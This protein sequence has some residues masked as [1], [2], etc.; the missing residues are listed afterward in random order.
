MSLQAVLRR[1]L[2][3]FSVVCLFHVNP[4]QAALVGLDPGSVAA[5][6]GE[7]LS[8]D[9]VI[10]GL[11]EFA[12]DSLGAFDV[13]VGFDVGALSFTSYSLGSLLGDIGLLEAIDASFGDLGGVINLAEVSLLAAASLDALQSSEFVLATLNFEVIDLAE[14][15]ITELLVQSSPVLADGFGARIDVTGVGRAVVEGRTSIPLPGTLVLFMRLASGLAFCHSQGFTPISIVTSYENQF[16][17]LLMRVL[18]QILFAIVVFTA[19]SHSFSQCA[20]AVPLLC[21]ADGDFD[22]DS[23][24]IAAI[25]AAKGT[26]SSGPGDVRDIDGDGVISVLDAR[27]CV[28]YCDEP[29]CIETNTMTPEEKLRE[30]EDAGLI[31]K[32]DRTEDY[33]QP[34]TNDNGIR[35]DIETYINTNFPV[36][37]QRSAVEQLARTVQGAILV[38]KTDAS[39]VKAESVRM[40]EAVNCIYT[41]FGS[42]SGVKPA[43][44][45][46]E[47]IEAITANTKLRLVEYLAF[48]KALDGTVSSIPGGDTC[49]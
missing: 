13:S 16:R 43:G 41:Q 9:L 10:S 23:D 14:G 12:P 48:S 25:G 20:G 49:E 19:S 4:S 29:N 7:V 3:A 39:A 44:R 33:L 30:L 46:I 6:D 15:S 21:D 8:L 1:V 34:D 24:D 17:R 42:G 28:A 37:T 5:G 2:F 35:D 45:V 22:I 11:G 26:P 27:Q 36:P 47:E 40:S 31:P 18:F 32:L 38:D